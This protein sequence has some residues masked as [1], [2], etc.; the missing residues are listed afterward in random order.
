M[1]VSVPRDFFLT[2][3]KKWAMQYHVATCCFVVDVVRSARG[4]WDEAKGAGAASCDWLVGLPLGLGIG[5]ETGQ[6]KTMIR[7][8]IFSSTTRAA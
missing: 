7:V 6:D 8:C 3:K 2:Q 5:E 1:C 4:G